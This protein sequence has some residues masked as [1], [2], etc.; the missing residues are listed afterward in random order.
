MKNERKRMQIASDHL[1]ADQGDFFFAKSRSHDGTISKRPVF[2]IGKNKDSND[3]DVI[4]CNCTSTI[5]RESDYDV[6]VQ[7]K[8]NTV[9]RAN[10]I[11]TISRKSLLFKIQHQVSEETI[12]QIFEKSMDAISIKN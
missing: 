3:S 7:L 5:D 6:P 9:V 12:Q 10:K 11:H 2:I 1:N 8:L 4:V